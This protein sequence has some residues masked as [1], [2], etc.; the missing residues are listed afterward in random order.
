MN[1]IN[2]VEQITCPCCHKTIDIN[3]SIPFCKGVYASDPVISLKDYLNIPKVKYFRQIH[4]P[5]TGR[6]DT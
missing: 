4:I 5:F 6:D 3:V 1:I 2:K